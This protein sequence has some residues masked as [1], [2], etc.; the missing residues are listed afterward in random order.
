V[1]EEEVESEEG[2]TEVDG[3]ESEG[4]KEEEESEGGDDKECDTL[5]DGEEDETS[6][7][8]DEAEE[9]EAEQD[10]L[11]SAISSSG[12]RSG[13]SGTLSSVPEGTPLSSIKASYKAKREKVDE[14][15]VELWKTKREKSASW[16]TEAARDELKATTGKSSTR[17]VVLVTPFWWTEQV[18][19]TNYEH[20]CSN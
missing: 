9:E 7:A 1:Q 17:A 8:A 18:K 5:V 6:E 11:D 13:R 16:N 20:R 19:N 15:E 4:D 12:G 2:G 10:G 3:E 14:E